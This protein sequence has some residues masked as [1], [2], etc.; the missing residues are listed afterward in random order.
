M[1]TARDKLNAYVTHET[2]EDQAEFARR[3]AAVIAEALNKAA[4]TI[5]ATD[6]PDDPVD[7]FDNGARWAT[8]H[9]RRVANETVQPAP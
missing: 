2:D 4:D 7:T 3:V 5:D 8:G 6:L 1:A 9:L